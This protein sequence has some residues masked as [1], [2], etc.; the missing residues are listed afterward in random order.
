MKVLQFGDPILKYISESVSIN[1]IVGEKYLNLIEQMKSVLNGI[2]NISSE[3][4]NA[5]AAPQMGVPI[6]L[7][8]LRIDGLFTPMFNPKFQPLSNDEIRLPEECFSFY[9]IRATIKRFDQIKVSYVD[10]KGDDREINANGELSAIIQH[11]IDH[12]NGSLFL[13]K[14]DSET[15]IES[16][17]H[18]YKNNPKKLAKVNRIIDYI[19][20]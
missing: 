9:N 11:E 18:T 2:Q 12:L 4:G 8:L 19:L 5:I 1:E 7:T 15:K 13:E 10:E 17:E 3:N 20:S 14:M 16:I 6:R